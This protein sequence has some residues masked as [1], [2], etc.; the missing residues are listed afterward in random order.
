MKS[1]SVSSKKIEFSAGGG[2]MAMFLKFNLADRENSRKVKY[3][4]RYDGP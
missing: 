2:D 3:H 4:E 1:V